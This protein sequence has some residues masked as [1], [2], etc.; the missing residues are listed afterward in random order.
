MGYV[1]GFSEILAFNGYVGESSSTGACFALL[2]RP[3]L[4]WASWLRQDLLGHV[5]VYIGEAAL[6]AIVIEAQAF[7]IQAQ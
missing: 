5:P 1:V 4:P 3:P 2:C 7:V 6:N